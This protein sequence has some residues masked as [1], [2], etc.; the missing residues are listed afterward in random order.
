MSGHFSTVAN[1]P[2]AFVVNE[3]GK[4]TVCGELVSYT[5]YDVMCI[6]Y[7][8]SLICNEEE[9]TGSVVQTGREQNKLL[10]YISVI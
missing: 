8:C 5:S 2:Y 1:P 3:A 6:L 10:I 7:F 9:I 4:K